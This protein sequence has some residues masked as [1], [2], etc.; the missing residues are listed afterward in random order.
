MNITKAT[1]LKLL[2]MCATLT[3]VLPAHAY[4]DPGAQRWINR[5]PIGEPGFELL[6]G[7]RM[8]NNGYPNL[9]VFVGNDPVQGIDELGL[10]YGN[11]IPPCA[12]YPECMKPSDDQI[13]KG[14][15]MCAKVLNAGCF[16]ACAAAVAA[17]AVSIGVG[18]PPVGIGGIA[19][20][21]AW[22]AALCSLICSQ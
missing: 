17:G 21:I 11:P 8:P 9:Y 22:G 19:G 12:P 2:F 16:T 4:Y 7:I 13:Q 1:W 5:D 20:S 6:R 10:A 14:K 18:A 3:E 15:S